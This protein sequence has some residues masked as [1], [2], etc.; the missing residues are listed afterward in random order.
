MN[1][2]N[3][4]YNKWTCSYKITVIVR[5]CEVFAKLSGKTYET[6]SAS[7]YF[8]VFH[9]QSYSTEIHEILYK[10]S[11]VIL[12]ITRNKNGHLNFFFL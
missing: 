10:L 4:H 7:L 2:K 11:N 6:G 5:N 8:C 9:I 3:F 12:T 1:T